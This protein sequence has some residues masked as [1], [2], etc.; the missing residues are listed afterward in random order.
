MNADLFRDRGGRRSLR[1]RR[2]R[3]NWG[4]LPEK[5]SGRLRRS[6][7]DRR[8]FKDPIIRIIG[9]ERRKVFRQFD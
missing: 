9:D 7:I 8:R 6:G 2:S 4:P 3:S 5:R 1:D